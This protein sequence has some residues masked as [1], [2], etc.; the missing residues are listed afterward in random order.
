M[1]RRVWITD[2]DAALLQFIYQHKVVSISQIQ[3]LYNRLYQTNKS[4]IYKKLQKWNQLKIIYTQN[5]SGG[6]HP[7][8]CVRLNKYGM[9]ILTKEQILLNPEDDYKYIK[10]PKHSQADHF[11]CTREV[12]IR[13]FLEFKFRSGTF[14]SL[15]PSETP[16]IDTKVKQTNLQHSVPAMVVPDWIL[17][18]NNAILNIESDTGSEQPKRIVE[19]VKKYVEYNAQSIE[20][21]E[22]HVL[23]VP[24]DSVD[25]DILR[26]VKV[27]AKDRSMRIATVKDCIIQASAHIIP[28]LHFHVV[29]SSRSGKVAYNI[30]TGKYRNH[31]Q[32]LENVISAIKGLDEKTFAVKQLEAESF[33]IADLHES[34][35]AN[36]HLLIK[37]TEGYNKVV[38]IKIMDEGSI[39]AIDEL[40]F[41]NRQVEKRLLKRPVD[42]ILAVYKYEDECTNDVMGEMW[43]LPHVLFTSLERLAS[44][45]LRKRKTFTVSVTP[46]KKGEVLFFEREVT[47]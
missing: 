18:S 8:K 43:N 5:Y 29:S 36:G 15:S 33:Y 7:L 12:I 34:L 38:L 16:Y 45:Q 39:K 37:D 30:L 6:K 31:E 28:D 24:P 44:D 13:T 47:S 42:K 1:G 17:I 40:Y 26:H 2:R 25:N 3:F 21:K 46:F 10:P 20:N 23:I 9:D 22:H 14:S 32:T 35:Y 27:P 41:L 19:K 4:S 11:F